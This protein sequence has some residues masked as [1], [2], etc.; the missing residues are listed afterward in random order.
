MRNHS[1]EEKAC[2]MNGEDDKLLKAE[3]NE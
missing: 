2:C 3:D 1:E